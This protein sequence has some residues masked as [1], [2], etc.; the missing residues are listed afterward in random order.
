MTKRLIR[1]KIC[2]NF[3]SNYCNKI[4]QDILHM[5][6]ANTCVFTR[7]KFKGE[8]L[9]NKIP[10]DIAFWRNQNIMRR[11][12]FKIIDNFRQFLLL[13]INFIHTL[14]FLLDY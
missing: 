7:L 6:F 3:V 1:N 4:F 8:N 11:Y 13:Q 14:N 12:L 9:A 5:I 10:W 2:K